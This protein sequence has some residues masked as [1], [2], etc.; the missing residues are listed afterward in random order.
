[1]AKCIVKFR[2]DAAVLFD[3][4]GHSINMLR[5]DQGHKPTAK[6]KARIKKGLM[7]GC[8]ELSKLHGLFL[9]KK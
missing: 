5:W 2:S 1:M 4:H 6:E 7:K 8:N 3:K 9:G